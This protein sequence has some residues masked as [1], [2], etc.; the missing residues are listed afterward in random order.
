MPPWERGE[1]PGRTGPHIDLSSV[2]L[3]PAFH[4]SHH[5]QFLTQRGGKICP[6]PVARPLG[7]AL[8]SGFSALQM[9]P[10]A[11][12]LPKSVDICCRLV[13]FLLFS[14]SLAVYLLFTTLLSFQWG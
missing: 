11:F 10:F 8:I 9:P 13:S 1:A 5:L 14:L 7:R 4:S 12:H 3:S 6:L 2:S